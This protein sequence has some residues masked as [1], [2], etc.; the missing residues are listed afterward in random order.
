MKRNTSLRK[1]TIT[2]D[3]VP[4]NHRS[5]Q[6][7]SR[8]LH[9]LIPR[10]NRFF[11][12]RGVCDPA[13]VSDGLNSMFIFFVTTFPAKWHAG[14]EGTLTRIQAC[15]LSEHFRLG[16]FRPS[17]LGLFGFCSFSLCSGFHVGR[18][19]ISRCFVNT[20]H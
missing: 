1:S 17:I 12:A 19:A 4:H 18:Q 13:I 7:S 3:F 2:S 16:I 11:E 6:F 8:I 10:G 14:H 15:R 5:H 9:D 20:R